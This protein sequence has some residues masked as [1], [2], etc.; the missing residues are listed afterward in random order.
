MLGEEEAKQASISTYYSAENHDFDFCQ[1]IF[2]QFR[3]IFGSLE[4]LKV[5]ISIIILVH[6]GQN[7]NVIELTSV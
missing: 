7:N 1:L 4:F 2:F 6:N 3:H 5:K